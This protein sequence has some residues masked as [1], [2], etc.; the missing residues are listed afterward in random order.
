MIISLTMWKKTG[1]ESFFLAMLWEKKLISKSL[2]KS[3]CICKIEW[4]IWIKML[5]DY[6]TSPPP[7]RQQQK[8]ISFILQVKFPI[9]LP[10]LLYR[11]PLM[12]FWALRPVYIINV[13]CKTH[14]HLKSHHKWAYWRLRATQLL[15]VLLSVLHRQGSKYPRKP[16]QGPYTDCPAL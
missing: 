3:P 6:T 11:G 9:I 12:S 7:S 2:I 10:H 14:T 16:T 15:V 8:L 13:T 1:T 5:K 4:G